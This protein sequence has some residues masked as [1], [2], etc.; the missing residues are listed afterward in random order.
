MRLI[1]ITNTLLTQP[2]YFCQCE[3]YA[4]I[5]GTTLTDNP[6]LTSVS[7]L[8][9]IVCTGRLTIDQCLQLTTLEGIN[10]PSV[11]T[12]WV[13]LTRND[14]LYGYHRRVE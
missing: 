1:E 5:V 7:G 10:I 3:W 2:E 6:D 14:A 13:A 11:V 12:D 9:N 8:K 4:G